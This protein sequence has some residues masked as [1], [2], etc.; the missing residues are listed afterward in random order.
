[1]LGLTVFREPY[2]ERENLVYAASLVFV[3]HTR[4]VGV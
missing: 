3:A 2:S 4:G 1:V